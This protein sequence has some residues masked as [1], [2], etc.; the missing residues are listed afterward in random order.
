[1]FYSKYLK[2]IFDIIASFFG[3][4]ILSPILI[5]TAVLVKKKL[6]SPVL[7]K[8]ARPGKDEKIFMMY[9]FRSMT[10][11]R[12]E[13]GK[14]LSD[15]ERLPSFGRKLRSSSLDELPELWNILKGDMSVVGPRPLFVD[16]L[17]YYY[18]EE[19]QR[20]N[21]RPGLTGLAQVNGRNSTEWNEKLQ[22]DVH[23]VNNC[24]IWLDTKIILVTIKKILKKEDVLVGKEIK[25]G[26]LDDLRKKEM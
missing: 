3:I 21:L 25:V 12:D 17:P 8:Q 16:Y 11:E 9:K 13:T 7:F 2:R 1:M 5:F 14:L 6:G 23:Y 19:R 4:I 26:R 20:H 24:S 18:E 15:D 10:D 22:L